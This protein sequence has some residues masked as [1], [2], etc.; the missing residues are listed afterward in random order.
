MI[1]HARNLKTLMRTTEF[2]VL[3][4]LCEDY[5]DIFSMVASA[6]FNRLELFYEE[7][8]RTPYVQGL[9]MSGELEQAIGK[10]ESKYAKIIH[11]CVLDPGRSPKEVSLLKEHKRLER[12]VRFIHRLAKV[13]GPSD[14]IFVFVKPFE[15]NKLRK[16]V[17]KSLDQAKGKLNL[18]LK[19]EFFQE[20]LLAEHHDIL[21]RLN[22]DIE[23]ATKFVAEVKP[24]YPIERIRD[25]DNVRAKTLINR[26]ADVC[27]RIYGYCDETVINHLTNYPWLDCVT[28]IAKIDDL[29]KQALSRK[30]HLF[31]RRIPN[32]DSDSG[33]WFKCR[34][35]EEDSES[36]E[37][38]GEWLPARTIDPPWMEA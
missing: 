21:K 22:R 6:D 25:E 33:G 3:S 23:K 16:Q 28:E 20:S 19:D 7:L 18:L 9:L 8:E 29:I 5:R 37:L 34:I 14:R 31:E 38:D 4:K 13:I 2:N 35:P 10:L 12:R 24:D 11:K 32:Q 26:L 36:V 17:V 30:I 15:Q 1:N 27:Y